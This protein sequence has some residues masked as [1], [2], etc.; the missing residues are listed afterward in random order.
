M[1]A[2][3]GTRGDAEI[4][5]DRRDGARVWF[6]MS[7]TPMLPFRSPRLPR[8]IFFVLPLGALAAVAAC[9]GGTT[10]PVG[11]SNGDDGGV[12]SSSS[13]TD[14]GMPTPGH[15]T[16]AL[17]YL[18]GSSFALLID[19][20]NAYALVENNDGNASTRIVEA[21]LSGGS[22]VTLAT[23]ASYATAIAAS[24]GQVYWVDPNG[25]PT[26]DAS[27]N[28]GVV[29]GVPTGG[30]V[31]ATVASGQGYPDLVAADA[32]GIYW[33]D[34]NV[35]EQ[36]PCTASAASVM[37]LPAGT[38][39][40]VVLASVTT[41]PSN[42]VLDASNVYWGT[43]DGRVVKLAKST[44]PGGTPTQL[45][46]YETNVQNLVVGA[47]DV[48]WTTGTGDIMRTPIAGGA[49]TA[50][51]VG[52]DTIRGLAVDAT[53][54]YF[55]TYGEDFTGA[56]SPP[57]TVNAL[58]LGGVGA[59]APTVLWSGADVPETIQ[60]DDSN[61]YFTTDSGWLWKLSPK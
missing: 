51:L 16:S 20:D 4:P 48:F 24:G 25:P 46:Y 18:G 35:C 28:D 27:A 21:P 43:N 42:L 14:S 36:S 39:T 23:D 32:S 12:A 49:S 33:V 57:S 17:A 11:A 31:P 50:V 9:S 15:T 59:A 37:V 2:Q 55:I 41:S 60:V 8:P 5:G 22:S 13:G 6:L 3:S 38:T 52:Q 40:P 45:A 58:A 26:A 10:T 1:E 56:T 53:S 44:T 47:T 54:L 61:V 29:L 34:A 7:R 19:A 30:G